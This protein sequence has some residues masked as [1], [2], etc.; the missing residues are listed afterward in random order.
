[1]RTV[2]GTVTPIVRV[3]AGQHHASIEIGSSRY[4]A[5]PDECTHLARQLLAAAHTLTT[6]SE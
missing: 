2:N 4:T 1:M 5:T 3:Y 6:E